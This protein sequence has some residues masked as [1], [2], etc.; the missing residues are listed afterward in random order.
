MPND[1]LS[2]RSP[3][4]SDVEVLASITVIVEPGGT[5]PG[6][7]VL[8]TG[9]LGNVLE[10][11]VLIA[12]EI[13]ASE[14]VRHVEI[15][16]AIAVIVTPGGSETVAVVVLVHSGRL[17]DVLEE[18]AAIRI[19]SISEKEIR[20]SILCVVV[21]CGI[22]VLVFA[23]E[24]DIAAEIQI[25]AAIVVK[26]C[27]GHS[28]KSTLRWTSKPKRIRTALKP[29]IAPVE[30][31]QRTRRAQHYQV[32][33]TAVAKIDE[34]RRRRVVK[35]PNS[36][37][38]GDV[39]QA[40]LSAL[41]EPVRKPAWLAHVNLILAIVVDVADGDAVVAVDVNAARRV[42]AGTPVRDTTSQLV[43]KRVCVPQKLLGHVCE[44][45]LDL[46]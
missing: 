11:S 5:H 41:V 3:H 37:V 14:V 15:R 12:V 36:S 38:F 35:N 18:T 33:Q 45:R 31:E 4:V 23:L 22:T 46:R 20:R 27:G 13:A 7:D 24:V 32:L 43:L 6:P 44:E 39:F 17:S 9:M 29:A 2:G 19:E 34:Q 1:S 25:D 28:G 10:P 8:H 26:V 42:E 40:A 21:G 30:K 16:P